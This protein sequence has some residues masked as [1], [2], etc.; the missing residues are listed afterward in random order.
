MLVWVVV[1]ILVIVS[2]G[3]RLNRLT[4]QMKVLRENQL[5]IDDYIKAESEMMDKKAEAA[6]KEADVSQSANK[7]EKEDTDV[8][9]TVPQSEELSE[10]TSKEEIKPPVP[11]GVRKVYLTFDD[12]PS[13]YTEEILDILDQ[14][15]VKA[16]FFVIGKE[17]EHSVE[18]YKEIVARGHT[19]GM[20]S[21]SHKYNEIYDSMDAFIAD[22]TSIRDYLTNITG[23]VPAFYRFPGGSS[24]QVCNTDMEEFIQYL[25]EQGI[26][27]FDWNV[28]SGDATSNTY[29]TQD[30]MDNVMMDVN[31]YDTSVVL[32]HDTS[33][34]HATV[35][36]LPALLEQLLADGDAILPIDESTAPVQHISAKS[37][38]Q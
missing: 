12:G 8:K 33:A 25:N 32:M 15:Q 30:V 7:K 6:Q 29:T 23:K 16:T 31:K 3:F 27:Y 20:H 18:M 9:E 26:T 17:D 35:E 24:N 5:V 21:F 14:Y 10:D 2:F 11:E 36:S 38:T 37:V 22:F 28:S 4:Q 1:S 19:L 34:K 13:I